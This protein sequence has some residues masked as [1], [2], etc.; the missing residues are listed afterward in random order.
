MSRYKYKLRKVKKTLQV[1]NTVSKIKNFKKLS[2]K[3][4]IYI[5]GNVAGL[6][7]I[8]ATPADSFS[9]ELLEVFDIFLE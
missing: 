9:N 7:L 3:D 8:L 4:K 2:K 5:A 1:N 6:L